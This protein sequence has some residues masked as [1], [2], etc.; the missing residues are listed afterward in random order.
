MTTM[1]PRRPGQLSTRQAVMGGLA[2]LAALA[3]MVAGLSLLIQ[4]G[5]DV[6]PDEGPAEPGAPPGEPCPQAGDVPTTVAAE[7]LIECPD[8]YDQQTV[9]YRGE[10]VRA[11]LRR[12]DRAWVHLNDDAYGLELGPLP[13]H[14]TAI[15][16]NSGIPVSIPLD[17]ADAITHVGD[18]RHHGDIIDVVGTFHRADPADDGGPTIQAHN[19]TIAQ[20]GRTISRPVSRPRVITAVVLA[21]LAVASTAAVRFRP[22]LPQSTTNRSTT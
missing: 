6:A 20:V 14:R 11:V 19:A 3:G 16:G 1:I 2:I 8:A 9:R 4:R 12:G 10:A 21:I 15:G 5:E 18:A 17:V 13:A 22:S 7:R